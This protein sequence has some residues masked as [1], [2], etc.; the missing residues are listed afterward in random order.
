LGGHLWLNADIFAGPGALISPLDAR[1]FV[2]LCAEYLPQAVLSLSWGSSML[3]TSRLYTAEMVEQMIEI[4]MSPLVKR[5]FGALGVHTL[6]P[7]SNVDGDD[8]Y[9]LAPAAS[10]QHITFAVAAEFALSS[11]KALKKLLDAVP[12]ASLTV[13]SGMGSLG[14]TPGTVQEIITTYG[15]TRCFLDLRVTKPCRSCS[16]NEGGALCGIQ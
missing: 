3:S 1:Q 16:S 12:G 11:S 10:C 8:G 15:K 2:R 4:C 9:L 14:V 6:S 13:F 7:R 5:P